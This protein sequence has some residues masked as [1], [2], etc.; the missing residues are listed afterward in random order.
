MQQ[1]TNHVRL[2]ACP[3]L[4]SMEQGRVDLLQRP[5]QGVIDY[6]TTSYARTTPTK[7][8]NAF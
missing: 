2:I 3:S 5:A 8:S 6:G 1:D 4:F 7:R